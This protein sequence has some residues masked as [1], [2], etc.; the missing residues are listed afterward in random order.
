MKSSTRINIDYVRR[1]LHKVSV[2]S[3]SFQSLEMELAPKLLAEQSSY[4]KNKT[5]QNKKKKHK[6]MLEALGIWCRW[7]QK[8]LRQ[9]WLLLEKD[10]K[11]KITP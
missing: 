7:R 11:G 4:Q 5:K 10:K 8:I 6:Q 3:G 9:S 2:E 1:C